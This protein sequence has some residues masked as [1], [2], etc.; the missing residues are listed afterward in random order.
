[1]FLYLPLDVLDSTSC[2]VLGYFLQFLS[3]S[4]AQKVPGGYAFVVL[5]FP[6]EV[7]RRTVIKSL[8]NRLETLSR[9]FPVSRVERLK[10][11]VELLEE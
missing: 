7:P 5:D 6:E 9:V 4:V 8:Q 1:M 3:S 11:G 10:T 2:L